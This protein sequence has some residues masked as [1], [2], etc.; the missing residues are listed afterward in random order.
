[1]NA[2]QSKVGKVGHVTPVRAAG[3][4]WHSNGAHGVTRLTYLK[5]TSRKQL[6]VGAAV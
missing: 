1:V 3:P 4:A 2:Q 5:L 6:S